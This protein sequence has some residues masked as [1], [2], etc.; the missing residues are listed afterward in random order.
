M[1]DDSDGDFFELASLLTSGWT[2]LV[3]AVITIAAGEA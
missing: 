2:A 3:F 1:I